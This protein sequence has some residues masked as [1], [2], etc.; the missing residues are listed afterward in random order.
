MHGHEMEKMQGRWRAFGWNAQVVDGHDVAQLVVAFD[1]ARRLTGKPSVLLAKTDK[2]HGVASISG[3]GGW[4]GKALKKGADLDAAL[5]EVGG[6]EPIPVPARERRGR[7]SRQPAP[8]LPSRR[9]DVNYKLGAEVATREAYGDALVKLGELSPDVVVLDAEVKNSTF[10][11]KFKKAHPTR[12]VECYIAEQN[13]IGAALGL[14][15]EGK[16]PFASSFACFLAR[17]FDQVRMAGLSQPPALVLCGSHAGVSIGEDGPSQMALEDLATARAIVGSTVLYPCDAVSAERLT[18][19]AAL[20]GGIVYIRTSRPKT[21]V[22]YG[23]DEGFP[24]G[25][26]KVLRSSPQDRAAIVGAGVT[27]F[28]ALEAHE[29]L[30]KDGIAVRVIDLYSV[31]PLDEETLRKAARET[32]RVVTVEDHYAA[33][34]IGEAVAAAVSGLAPVRALAVREV[35]R[36]GQ[37]AEL[38]RAYGI[39]A[40]AIVKAV[41]ESLA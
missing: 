13:M 37:P 2:G 11:E 18:E 8:R 38:M 23:N 40:G 9:I 30:K 29:A 17:G 39:D 1:A 25:G 34:G 35:P 22:I 4:H 14:G 36:S 16:L 41:R 10:A 15:V 19:A 3:Q 6:E 20:Q 28:G 24:V 7:D 26:S 12:Y 33:G 27:V 21:K 32:G 5:R 31:K